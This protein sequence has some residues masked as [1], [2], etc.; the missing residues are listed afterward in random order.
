MTL[1][2]ALLETAGRLV[3]YGAAIYAAI[4][5]MARIAAL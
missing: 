1:R 5:L 4:W 3:L 2:R